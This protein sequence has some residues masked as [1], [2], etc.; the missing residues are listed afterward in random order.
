MRRAFVVGLM[1]LR[2]LGI[3]SMD[4]E[5]LG[6]GTLAVFQRGPGALREFIP[7]LHLFSIFQDPL[8]TPAY[9]DNRTTWLQR[10]SIPWGLEL[11]SFAVTNTMSSP[12]PAVT[13]TQDRH[14]ND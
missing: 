1:R 3:I 13:N 7:L 8:L 9:G 5:A 11:R 14:P 10:A 2:R 6:T 12:L 4:D